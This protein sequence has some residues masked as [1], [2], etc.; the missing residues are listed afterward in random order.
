LDTGPLPGGLF[1]SQS[2]R[3]PQNASAISIFV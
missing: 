2:L 3:W 1:N